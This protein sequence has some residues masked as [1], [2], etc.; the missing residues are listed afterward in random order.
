MYVVQ[1]VRWDFNGEFFFRVGLVGAGTLDDEDEAA[2]TEPGFVRPDPA[3]ARRRFLDAEARRKWSDHGPFA[4]GG[5]AALEPPQLSDGTSLPPEEFHGR[6]AAMAGPP[7]PPSAQAPWTDWV[8][9]WRARVPS[10]SYEKRQT[11]WD[12]ADRVCFHRVVAMD[13][14]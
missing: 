14:G 12:L 9:R 7:P 3:E 4:F 8:Q 13:R 11:I 6:V 10:L 2:V 1:R 5:D